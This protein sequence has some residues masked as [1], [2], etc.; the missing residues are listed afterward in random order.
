MVCE[1][2]RTRLRALHDHLS[3]LIVT[4]DALDLHQRADVVQVATLRVFHV[5]RVLGHGDQINGVLRGVLERSHGFASPD[6]Q[7]LHDLRKHDDVLQR[8]C[9]V[10][11]W[12][13]HVLWPPG[14]E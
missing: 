12:D 3:A 5:C 1:R 9:W 6:C 11:G 2:M 4:L 10:G 7:V 8:K 13:G 14:R